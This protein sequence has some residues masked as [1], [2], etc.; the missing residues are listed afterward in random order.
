M[1][2]VHTEISVLSTMYLHIGRCIH[3]LCF[4]T[5]WYQCFNGFGAFRLYL[6]L[7]PTSTPS[8]GEQGAT[9]ISWLTEKV[10]CNSVKFNW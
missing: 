5:L 1:E 7:N 6:A 9:G 4:E 3:S 2:V 8:R 10:P